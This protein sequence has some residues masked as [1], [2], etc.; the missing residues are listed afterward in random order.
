[1][2]DREVVYQI[3]S[4]EIVRA[5][6]NQIRACKQF[7]GIF[8]PHI[9]YMSLTDNLRIEQG[10]LPACRNCFRE[11][12]SRVGFVEQCLPL[13]VAGFNV[14]SIKDPQRSHAS[15]RQKG[16]QCGSSRPAAH[17]R[18]SACQQPLLAHFTNSR[19]KHLPRISSVNLGFH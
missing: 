5:I 19:E 13:Q 10:N 1:M 17:N 6:E 4:F 16:S 2:F 3:A 14:V 11:R 15:P 18:H 9:A 7:R 8:R 12:L